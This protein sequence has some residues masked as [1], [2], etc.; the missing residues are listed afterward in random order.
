LL[1]ALASFA[2]VTA[3]SEFLVLGGISQRRNGVLQGN[4]ALLT[5]HG[6]F[7]SGFS[8]PQRVY[9]AEYRIV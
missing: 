3:D 2:D 7:A 8:S 9:F 6:Q 5:Q 4:C 1:F